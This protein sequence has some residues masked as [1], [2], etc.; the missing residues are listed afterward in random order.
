MLGEVRGDSRCSGAGLGTQRGD[1][2]TIC[3]GGAWPMRLH[4]LFA[5]QAALTFLVA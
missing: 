1:S 4:L 2:P 5:I 3:T